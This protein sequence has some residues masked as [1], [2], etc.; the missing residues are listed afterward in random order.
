MRFTITG[1]SWLWEVIE[2]VR[3]HEDWPSSELAALHLLVE[4]LA[5]RGVDVA[6]LMARYPLEP[7]VPA[8][9]GQVVP[10]RKPDGTPIA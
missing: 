3:K 2:L 6:A 1:P 4:A 10:F 9:P 8:P 7:P 5:A